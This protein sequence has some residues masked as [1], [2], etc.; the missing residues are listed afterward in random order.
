MSSPIFILAGIG[1]LAS[2][3]AT[4]FAV[5]VIGIRRGDRS[6]L[7]NSPDSNSDAFA[8]RNLV[9]VRYPDFTMTA[10][11]ITSD[12]AAITATVSQIAQSNE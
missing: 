5:L 11:K 1:I 10:S 7:S 3:A 9:G 8:R 12:L 2:V 6:H 4:I